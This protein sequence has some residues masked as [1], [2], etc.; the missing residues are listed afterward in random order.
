M[1]IYFAIETGSVRIQTGKRNP[2]EMQR[3]KRAPH[4]EDP[5][6]AKLKGLYQYERTLELQARYQMAFIEVTYR[7]SGGGPAKNLLLRQSHCRYIPHQMKK[8]NL[9]CTVLPGP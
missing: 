4:N 9:R 6:L 2:E 7:I 8:C 3:R 1:K 5:Q